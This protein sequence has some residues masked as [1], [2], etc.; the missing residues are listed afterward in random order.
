MELTR[1]SND[2]MRTFVA[3]AL[4]QDP[5]ASSAQ[6]AV[7]WR[8]LRGETLSTEEMDRLTQ[9]YD[10]QAPA[11]HEANSEHRAAQGRID[12]PPFRLIKQEIA[13][14]I[15]VVVPFVFP[16]ESI[17]II[18]R[19]GVMTSGSYFSLGGVIGGIVAIGLALSI[20]Q[21]ALRGGSAAGVKM[22]H[23]AIGVGILLLGAYH[24]LHGIGV[25]HNLGIFRLA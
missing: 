19:D 1:Q 20:L 5:E 25:L 21:F 17:N 3:G 24:V 12:S 2:S 13:G 16:V 23:A 6:V 14:F 11:A 7:R 9:T 8:S 22:S 4:A 15:A 10:L 18:R